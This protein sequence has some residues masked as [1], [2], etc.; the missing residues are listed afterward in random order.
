MM[1]I[2]D[3]VDD[4]VIHYVHELLILIDLGVL[5]LDKGISYKI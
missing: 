2:Y 5:D 3:E 4:Y 1:S